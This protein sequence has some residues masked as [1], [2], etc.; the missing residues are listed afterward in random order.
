MSFVLIAAEMSTFWDLG[1]QHLTGPA[2]DPEVTYLK[3]QNS[4]IRAPQATPMDRFLIQNLNNRYA[5]TLCVPIATLV[6]PYKNPL[7]TSS[8]CNFGTLPEHELKSHSVILTWSFIKLYV[9][10]AINFV[11]CIHRF[12]YENNSLNQWL[13]FN[14]HCHSLLHKLQGPE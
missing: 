13:Y 9:T 11:N 10:W 2:N 14:N 6:L 12:W 7:C 5:L 3:I 1:K 4:L 8:C